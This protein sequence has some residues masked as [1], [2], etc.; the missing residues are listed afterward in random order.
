MSDVPPPETRIGAASKAQSMEGSKVSSGKH[1][2]CLPA[3][4]V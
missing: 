1:P 4:Q 2:T 3:E